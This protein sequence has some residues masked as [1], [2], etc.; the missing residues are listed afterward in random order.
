MA[1]LEG[2]VPALRSIIQPLRVGIQHVRQRIL[3]FNVYALALLKVAERLARSP[4]FMQQESFVLVENAT[5]EAMVQRHRK[6]FLGDAAV[7]LV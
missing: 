4:L 5:D 3:D 2:T 6:Q 7:K 1:L